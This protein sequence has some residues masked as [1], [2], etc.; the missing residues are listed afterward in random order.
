MTYTLV[1]KESLSQVQSQVL[2]KK[3]RKS[4]I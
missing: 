3:P 2:Q 4:K 1:E